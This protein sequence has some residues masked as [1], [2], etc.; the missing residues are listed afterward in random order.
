MARTSQQIY[1]AMIAD[2]ANY[3]SL[4]VLSSTS[5]VAIY[6]L[7]LRIVASAIAVL[8]QFFDIQKT[9]VQAIVDSSPFMTDRWIADKVLEFQDGDD[10]EVNAEYQLFYEL[11]DESKQIVTVSSCITDGFGR[12]LLKV[13][14]GEQGSYEALSGA[15]LARLQAYV[16]DIKPVGTQ[17]TTQ[18]LNADLVKAQFEVYY[19]ASLV[20]ADIQSAVLDAISS[21]L[22]LQPFNGIFRI[23]QLVDAI[24]AVDGVV[25]VVVS[26]VEARADTGTYASVNRIYQPESGYMILDQANSTFNYTVE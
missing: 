5:E 19:D 13:A 24:Q 14:K 15:E 7:I 10:L 1:D 8:E 6:K 25:D 9:E 12:A 23:S 3:P 17:V 20:L 2:K 16:S 11:L 21:F 22:V 18:S 4:G 26:S